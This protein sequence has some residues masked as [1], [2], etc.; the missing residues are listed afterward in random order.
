V[1]TPDVV[2]LCVP[3][4]LH[5]PLVLQA[6]DAGKHVVVEKPLTG[7]FVRK[8]ELGAPEMMERAVAQADALVAAAERRGSV[9]L[10]RRETGCTRRRSRRSQ[11]L[12]DDAG[13]AILRIQGEESH[14]GTHSEPNKHWITAG[15]GALLGKG[16]PSRSAPR[17]I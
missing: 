6:L 11:A 4:H 5:A 9:V 14:S 15:G 12:L 2:D 16:L 3:N 1:P 17:C 13:G 8:D 10:L 7:C